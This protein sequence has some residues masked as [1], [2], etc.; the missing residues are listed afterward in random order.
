M[1]LSHIKLGK[2]C[3]KG[4]WAFR[5]E[6]QVEDGWFRASG[7]VWHLGSCFLRV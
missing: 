4:Y 6:K 7:R 2:S 5:V 1:H 3:S